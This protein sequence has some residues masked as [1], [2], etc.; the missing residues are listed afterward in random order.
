M[1]PIPLRVGVTLHVG[2]V[3]KSKDFVVVVVMGEDSGGDQRECQE[4]EG[5]RQA[6]AEHALSF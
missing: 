2:S 5:T 3:S 4:R 6:W 1:K